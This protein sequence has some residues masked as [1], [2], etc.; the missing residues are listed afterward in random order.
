VRLTDSFF[1]LLEH[2]DGHH[3]IPT[4]VPSPLASNKTTMAIDE[5]DIAAAT[6]VFPYQQLYAQPGSKAYGYTP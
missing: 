4:T 5:D 1:Y 2:L 6:Y 3:F